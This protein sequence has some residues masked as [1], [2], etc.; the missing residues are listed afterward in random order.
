MAIAAMLLVLLFALCAQASAATE[1]GT[2]VIDEPQPCASLCEP[3]PKIEGPAP[4]P[5]RSVL[6]IGAGWDSGV[7]ATSSSLEH[8][9]VGSYVSYVNGKVNEWFALSNPGFHPWQAQAGGEYVIQSPHFTSTDPKACDSQAI[10]KEV[11]ERAMAAARKAGLE[12][13]KY[14][15][16]MVE[17]ENPSLCGH[18][19]IQVH[20]TNQVLVAR[21]GTA[22]I[23]ELGHFLGLPHAAAIHCKGADGKA[24]PL[25]GNCTF[26]EYAD[27]YDLMGQGTGAFN[28]AYANRLGWLNGQFFNL[29]AGNYTR[30]LTIRPWTGTVQS[31]RALRLQDGPTTLWFE[32][33]AA[34]GVDGFLFLTD[35]RASSNLGVVVHREGKFAGE[36]SD[37]TSQLLDMNPNPV[38]PNFQ[39]APME[40]GQTWA[41]P[42][43]TMK[44]TLNSLDA[45]GATLTVSSQYVPV[46]DVVGGD[47]KNAVTRIGAAGLHFAGSTNVKT[48]SCDEIGKV[49]STTPA[50]GT[51]V[52]PGTDVTVKIGEGNIK[53]ICQ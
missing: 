33:R 40:T 15:V 41:N 35:Y 31:E 2:G 17:I 51:G 28:A 39:H 30:T 24:V 49:V 8:H 42:L 29:G 1:T 47:R 36:L 9:E 37:S 48:T 19:G 14:A 50:A 18:A 13:D 26:E 20:A 4:D 45:S 32:Y 38:Y 11:I 23:H 44:V 7:A 6:V 43:G 16:A 25:S 12:P 21:K 46:P 27:P 34:T 53:L 52:E 22:P 10:Y 3:P 5:T